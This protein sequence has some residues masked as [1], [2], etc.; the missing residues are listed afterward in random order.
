MLSD[1]PSML[2]RPLYGAMPPQQQQDVFEAAPEV[3]WWTVVAP[4]KKNQ[5]SFCCLSLVSYCMVLV[6]AIQ[7]MD[8]GMLSNK[9]TYA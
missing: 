7:A 2:V 6:A 3:W 8:I 1:F 5:I 9:F 4:F